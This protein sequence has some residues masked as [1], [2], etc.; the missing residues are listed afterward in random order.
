MPHAKRP[1]SLCAVRAPG[2]IRERSSTANAWQPLLPSYDI[3]ADERSPEEV[4]GLCTTEE[5]PLVQRG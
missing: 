5:N 1:K 2:S 3:K 4:M